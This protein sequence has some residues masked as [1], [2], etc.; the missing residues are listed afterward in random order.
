MADISSAATRMVA[1][2]SGCELQAHQARCPVVAVQLARTRH[3]VDHGD[4]VGIEAVAKAQQAG[5]AQRRHESRVHQFTA[6]ALSLLPL[7]RLR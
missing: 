3:A 1:L 5:Q 7:Q 4:V 6:H 2:W